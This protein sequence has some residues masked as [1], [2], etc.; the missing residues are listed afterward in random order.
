MRLYT[1]ARVEEIIIAWRVSDVLSVEVLKCHRHSVTP[2]ARRSVGA[3][4]R[5]LAGSLIF[6]LVRYVLKRRVSCGLLPLTPD[7]QEISD[8]AEADRARRP[9]ERGDQVMDAETR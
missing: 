5:A 6:N 2:I 4:T 3:A 8:H 9:G 1:P 7:P